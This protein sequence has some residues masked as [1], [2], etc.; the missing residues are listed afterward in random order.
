MTKCYQYTADGYFVGK[1]EDYGLLPNNATYTK[2]PAIK[3]DLWPCW[4]EGDWVQV[5]DHRKR[6]G[7]PDLIARYGADYPQGATEHWLPGDTHETPARM[8]K[9]V[10]PLP[11][12]ALL[13]RPA[14]PEPTTE[15]LANTARAE[16]DQLIES[17]RWRIE[18]HNDEVALGIEPT[19][20]LEPLL[21][22]VQDLR[23]VPQQSGFPEYI[24]W[25]MLSE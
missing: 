24:E 19:E 25:P 14:K 22:Y 5:E 1:V 2:P 11:D 18:R 15:Q 20:P 7:L 8:M 6:E 23:D 4:Q 12:G 13:E 16:R 17:V 9:K 3:K 21:Q 10:G